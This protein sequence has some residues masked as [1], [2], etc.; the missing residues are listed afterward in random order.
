ML[1][2]D[3]GCAIEYLASKHTPT[4][5]PEIRL[6]G[7]PSLLS[8]HLYHSPATVSSGEAPVWLAEGIASADV[9]DLC[10]STLLTSEGSWANLPMAGER[11]REARAPVVQC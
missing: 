5:K 8:L 9:I 3:K 11:K 4:T 6:K 10:A 1:K 2:Q 7:Y